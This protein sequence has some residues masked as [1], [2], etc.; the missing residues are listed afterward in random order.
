MNRSR[1][2]KTVLARSKTHELEAWPRMVSP[3]QNRL[4]FPAGGGGMEEGRRMRVFLIFN[5]TMEGPEIREILC[6]IEA[7][8]T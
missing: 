7:K 6:T 1:Q 2:K 3:L 5:D 4:F 8:E